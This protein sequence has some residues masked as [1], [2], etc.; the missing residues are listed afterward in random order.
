MN[1]QFFAKKI[2]LFLFFALFSTLFFS[3]TFNLVLDFFFN[4]KI[5]DL[6]LKFFS[7][8]EI[9]NSKIINIFKL[10]TLFNTLG[11]F[12]IPSLFYFF[13]FKKK[14]Y[15]SFKRFKFKYRDI[16]LLITICLLSFP[17][18][19]RLHQINILLNP[20]DFLSEIINQ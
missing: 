12:L 20:P 15:L 5:D 4:I 18:V 10:Q 17:V 2:F 1:D 13:F 11:M 9:I 6:N 16:V 3:L 7:G 19:E 14:F 8:E